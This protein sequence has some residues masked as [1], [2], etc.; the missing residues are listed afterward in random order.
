[1]NSAIDRAVA[2]TRRKALTRALYRCVTAPDSESYKTEALAGDP[3][4]L[5]TT[6]AIS[7]A[8]LYQV[9]NLPISEAMF[10]CEPG[11]ISMAFSGQII[12]S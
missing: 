2:C 12:A 4:L 8:C 11:S 6:P 9:V 7:G 10:G 3:S 1:M 5:S